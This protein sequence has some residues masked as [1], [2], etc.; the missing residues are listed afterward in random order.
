LFFSGRRPVWGFFFAFFILL[1][2]FF[3]FSVLLLVFSVLPFPALGSGVHGICFRLWGP[4][5]ADFA[6]RRAG[7]VR[8]VLPA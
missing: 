4:G 5:F 3:A 2:L 8:V 7:G 6:L 1:F